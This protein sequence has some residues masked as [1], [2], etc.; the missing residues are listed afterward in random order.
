PSGDRRRMPGRDGVGDSRGQ[1]R[2]RI[3]WRGLRTGVGRHA[4][5]AQE[6]GTERIRPPRRLGG[7]GADRPLPQGPRVHHGLP[8]GRLVRRRCR[9]RRVAAQAARAAGRR[10]GGGYRCAAAGR[11][12]KM[13]KTP[14]LN[15]TLPATSA[16]LGP[17]FDSAALAMKLHLRIKAEVAPEFS[18]RAAGRDAGICGQLEPNLILDTYRDVLESHGRQPVPL[19]LTIRND[20]PI[21]KGTGSSA[22]ARLAAISMAVHFGG[23][24][25]KDDRILSEAA[26]REKHVDNVA[27]CWLGGVGLVYPGGAMRLRTRMPWPLLL[28]VT[29]ETLLTEHSRAIL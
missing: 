7:A 26:R 3:R 29:R 13:A 20:M 12:L 25:W 23:L 10:S 17:A 24:K 4:G 27:G 28:A 2:D 11:E 21:G 5:G 1:G 16:N 8:S 19:A 14:A 6:V 18:I 15:L 22:A 9:S